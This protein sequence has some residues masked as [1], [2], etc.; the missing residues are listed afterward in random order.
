M[1]LDDGGDATGLVMLGSKAEQDIAVLD[2]PGNEEEIFL[3]ARLAKLAQDL[4]D[5]APR[6]RSRA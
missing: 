5:P 6:P 1:I 4:S 3:F 2:N